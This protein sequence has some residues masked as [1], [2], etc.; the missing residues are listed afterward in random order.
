MVS[1]TQ[2]IVPTLILLQ[3]R[4]YKK[5]D[6]I[7]KTYIRNYLKTGI[8]DELTENIIEYESDRIYANISPYYTPSNKENKAI[9]QAYWETYIKT[10]RT[11]V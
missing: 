5:D 10:G 3:K 7:V 9:V 4:W 1:R 8:K 2:S 6:K 11:I